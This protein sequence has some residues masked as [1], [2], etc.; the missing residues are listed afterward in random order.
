MRVSFVQHRSNRIGFLHSRITED[1]DV[2]RRVPE[3]VAGHFGISPHRHLHFPFV[4]LLFEENVGDLIA[5]LFIPN[6]NELPGLAVASRWSPAGAI[7]NFSY[8]LI[9]NTFGFIVSTNTSSV[10]G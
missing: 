4:F 10:G 1:D 5:R 2:N 3:A 7:E 8:H 9:R 6:H